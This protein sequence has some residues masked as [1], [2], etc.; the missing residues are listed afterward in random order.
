MSNRGVGNRLVVCPEV[1]LPEQDPVVDNPW[2]QEEYLE[3]DNRQDSQRDNQGADN[4]LDSRRDNQGCS[5][6]AINLQDNPEVDNQG[7]VSRAD[8]EEDSQEDREE[9]PVVGNQAAESLVPISP[10]ARENADIAAI[11]IIMSGCKIA[12]YPPCAWMG[13]VLRSGLKEVHPADLGARAMQIVP[14]PMRVQ[15]A[16]V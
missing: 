8:P 1:R 16:G 13:L 4:R 9:D 14:R 2:D 6:E 7:A 5:P 11:K 12:A 3:A 15:W 10:V